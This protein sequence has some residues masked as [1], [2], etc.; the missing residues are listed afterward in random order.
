MFCR[1]EG[2]RLIYHS[3][4]IISYRHKKYIIGLSVDGSLL[5]LQFTTVA[6]YHQCRRRAI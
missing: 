5:F 4:K 3:L 6:R 1:M 2:C